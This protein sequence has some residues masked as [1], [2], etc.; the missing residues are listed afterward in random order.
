M[1]V[2]EFVE[3]SERRPDP[4]R[5]PIPGLGA[6]LLLP[7]P[8]PPNVAPGGGVPRR[9][10]GG[11]GDAVVLVGAVSSLP[12]NDLQLLSLSALAFSSLLRSNAERYRSYPS[13][14]DFSTRFEKINSPRGLLDGGM[15]AMIVLVDGLRGPSLGGTLTLTVGVEDGV[16]YQ[17]RYARTEKRG[18]RMLRCI[19]SGRNALLE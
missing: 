16:V 15:V 2:V 11:V 3:L 13:R 1:D 19:L 18:R 6:L 12:H 9:L 7:P 17:G 5:M 4:P 14:N 10:T 8:L